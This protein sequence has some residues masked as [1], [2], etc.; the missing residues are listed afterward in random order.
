MSFLFKKKPKPEKTQEE[1]DRENN[2]LREFRASRQS[3]SIQARFCDASESF[4]IDSCIDFKFDTEPQGRW[5]VGA[6]VRFVLPV[7]A[8]RRA[9]Q[10]FKTAS[11]VKERAAVCF[12]SEIYSDSDLR[13]CT[14]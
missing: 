13:C 14:P 5:L 10:E 3:V 4:A 6:P 8:F 1:K 11:I 2:A 12:R 9:V 7:V